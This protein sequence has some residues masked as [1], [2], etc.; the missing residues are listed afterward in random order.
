MRQSIGIILFALAGT[1]FSATPKDG[2]SQA[3]QT[4]RPSLT[5]AQVQ[6]EVAKSHEVM[7][8]WNEERKDF[9]AK[10]LGLAKDTIAAVDRLTD[11]STARLKKV[12]SDIEHIPALIADKDIPERINSITREYED[13]ILQLLGREH[14]TQA[15]EF[16]N[17]FNKNI[18]ARFKVEAQITGF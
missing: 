4:S 6:A 15:I 7:K 9:Y 13:Q 11:G 17:G 2:I 3:P 5:D 8:Y 14:M 12:M 18:F 16:R 1:A 10:E